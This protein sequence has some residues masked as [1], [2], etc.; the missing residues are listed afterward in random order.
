MIGAYVLV[1]TLNE[2]WL[3]KTKHYHL[4]H[5]YAMV[6]DDDDCHNYVGSKVIVL[7]FIWVLIVVI[8]MQ[9]VH[10]KMLVASFSA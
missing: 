3:I 5:L 7:I 6:K 10:F 1:S 9:S 4:S 2:D 8:V